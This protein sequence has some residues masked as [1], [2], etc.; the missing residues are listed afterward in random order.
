MI[1]Y[2]KSLHENDIA[3]SFLS[4]ALLTHSVLQVTI[5]DKSIR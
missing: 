3:V 5:E 4:V 1:V 2:Q